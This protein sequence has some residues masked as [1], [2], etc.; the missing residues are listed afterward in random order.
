MF[1]NRKFSLHHLLTVFNSFFVFVLNSSLTLMASSKTLIY[2]VLTVGIGTILV[3]IRIHNLHKRIVFNPLNS[4]WNNKNAD[5][6]ATVSRRQANG[7]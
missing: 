2:F 1:S 5:G 4:I 6:L 3:I 7:I